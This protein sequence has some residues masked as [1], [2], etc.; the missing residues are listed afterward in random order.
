MNT[1]FNLDKAMLKRLSRRALIFFAMVAVLKTASL[2]LLY[3]LPATGVTK[4]ILPTR[5]DEYITLDAGDLFDIQQASASKTDKAKEQAAKAT[6]YPLTALKIKAIF[7]SPS[8]SFVTLE[9]GK[10]VV[11]LDIDQS[12]KGYTLHKVYPK[13]AIFTRGGKQ[14][15]LT[16]ADET[17]KKADRAL[18][19]STAHH[20]AVQTL[21]NVPRDEIKSYQ[22]DMSK[23]WSNIG[24]KEHK[25]AGKTDGFVVTFVKN[26]SVFEQLGLQKGDILTE[27]NGIKIASYKDALKLYKKIDTIKVFKLTI[28]RNNEEKE[29]EYEIF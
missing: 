18:K 24:L 25:S 22:K 20:Q 5:L 3:F 27:A 11:F 6:T 21:K 12:F 15:E 16:L 7:H 14:Y 19:K 8:L 1:L 2:V 29:L 23:I 13:K 17:D 9:D 28:L 4:S 10:E 26:G